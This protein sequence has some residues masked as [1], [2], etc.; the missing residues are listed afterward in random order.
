MLEYLQTNTKDLDFQYLV[1]LLDADLALRDGEE[2]DFYAQF[3]GIEN[4]PHAL[5]AYQDGQAVGCGAIKPFDE[6]SVEV[7]RMYV[8][9]EKRGQGI[10][11][12]IL[13]ALEEWATAL[14]Y[15]RCVLETGKKQMEAL[16]LYAKMGYSLIPNYG[17]YQ[18]VP[19]SVCFEKRLSDEK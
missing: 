17:Q 12:G 9:P 3:N 1:K 10:A 4:I 16:A 8:L 2:H 15:K 5:L 18:N 13:Q 19:N 6:E 14:H 11:S 7:K